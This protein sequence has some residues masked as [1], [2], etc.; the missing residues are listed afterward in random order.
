MYCE[1]TPFHPIGAEKW[2]FT[3]MLAA[4]P[5][6]ARRT[7]ISLTS[8]HL[9]LGKHSSAHMIPVQMEEQEECPE[10]KNKDISFEKCLE[11]PSETDDGGLHRRLSARHVFMI[12]LV[13]A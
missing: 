3:W 8:L 13:C 2:T 4:S 5:R 7:L 10:D 1:T 12:W 9:I 6:R 11:P